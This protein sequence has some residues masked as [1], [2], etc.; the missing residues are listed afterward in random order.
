MKLDVVCKKQD[1]YMTPYY[2]VDPILK[3]L[4]NFQTIWCPFDT[5]ES[6]FVVALRGGGA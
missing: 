1:E 5:D 4:D 2:A 6:L 3:Y